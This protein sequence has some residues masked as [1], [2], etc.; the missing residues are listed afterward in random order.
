[1]LFKL[2]KNTNQTV[3]T[4]CLMLYCYLPVFEC[5]LV[6]FFCNQIALLTYWIYCADSVIM[7]INLEKNSHSYLALK[8]ILKKYIIIL[9]YLQKLPSYTP[10]L[11]IKPKQ[12][13]HRET[14]NSSIFRNPATNNTICPIQT[15]VIFRAQ[16]I[17]IFI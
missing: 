2:N 15:K 9:S 4:G 5:S 11:P 8:N 10:S 14:Q 3:E 12:L 17:D 13:L 7:P 1:M 16:G 6:L